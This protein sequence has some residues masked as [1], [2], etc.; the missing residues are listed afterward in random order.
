MKIRL[1]CL[2]AALLVAG[3]AWA[4]DERHIRDIDRADTLAD[5][6]TLADDIVK[7]Q[8]IKKTA[9]PE[10]AILVAVDTQVY[11]AYIRIKMDKLM[12]DQLQTL[13]DRQPPTLPTP[14]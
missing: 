1:L 14:R 6:T 5:L 11:L 13:I 7:A 3:G 4:L 2:L 9:T 8:G 12:C 10:D